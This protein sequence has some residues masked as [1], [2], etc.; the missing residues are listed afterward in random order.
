VNETEER[1]YK[2]PHRWQALLPYGHTFR[3]TDG[4]DCLNEALVH[5]QV[6]GHLG[7]TMWTKSMILAGGGRVRYSR[8]V[9]ARQRSVCKW[10]RKLAFFPIEGHMLIGPSVGKIPQCHGW[11]KFMT[12]RNVIKIDGGSDEAQPSMSWVNWRLARRRIDAAVAGSGIVPTRDCYS[13]DGKRPGLSIPVSSR[14]PRAGGTGSTARVGAKAV[15][16]S[17]DG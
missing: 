2:L 7:L 17:L 6:E 16:L 10:M 14:H 8:E 15:A 3:G 13:N 4:F 9:G 5:H 11:K 1:S 12:N